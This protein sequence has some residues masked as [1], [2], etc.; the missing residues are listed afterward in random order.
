MKPSNHESMT[1]EKLHN[2]PA[3]SLLLLLPHDDILPFVERQFKSKTIT[4]R[5]YLTLNIF[6]VLFTLVVAILDIGQGNIGF[7]AVLKY[8]GI[9]SLLVFTILIPVH[10][11]LH[12]LAY[13]MVGAH[14]ISFGVNWRMFYFYAVADRFISDRKSFKFIALTPF[15]CISLFAIIAIIFGS[16]AGKWISIGILVL[17]TTACAGDFAMLSF[18][19]EYQDAEELLTYD[20]VSQKQSYFYV[21][22]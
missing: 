7:W 5:T 2:D 12:G 17:H 1:I 8:F 11:G 9:G 15:I 22:E 14:K 18:Y 21:R 16:I 13:K 19:E 20:D 6:L 3:Y 10:E 4:I